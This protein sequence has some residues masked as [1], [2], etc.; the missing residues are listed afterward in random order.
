MMNSHFT[1]YWPIER[2][3]HRIP[4]N[5]PH[6]GQWRGALILSVI[7]AWIND[8]VNTRQAGDLRRHGDHYDVTVMLE[9]TKVWS[10]I[11]YQP[12]IIHHVSNIMLAIWGVL[13]TWIPSKVCVRMYIW[14]YAYI[15]P[16]NKYLNLSPY[17]NGYITSVLIPVDVLTFR[18][19][20][21]NCRKILYYIELG[22]V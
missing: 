5:S 17:I 7:C 20:A 3:L 2:G 22:T 21:R 14:Y 9:G 1:R 19:D 8:W 10:L 11:E 15:H 6:K 13:Q 18:F 4:V 16:H 12:T